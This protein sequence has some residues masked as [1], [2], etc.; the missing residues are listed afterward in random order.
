VGASLRQVDRCVDRKIDGSVFGGPRSWG[1][2]GALD[3][4]V[5]FRTADLWPFLTRKRWTKHLIL[6]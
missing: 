3:T 5:L 6:T 2:A 1:M 4:L